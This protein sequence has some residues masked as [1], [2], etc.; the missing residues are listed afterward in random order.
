MACQL[1]DGGEE[2]LVPTRQNH[3]QIRFQ[4]LAFRGRWCLD[5]TQ[6]H[7]DLDLHIAHRSTLWQVGP[8]LWEDC[9]QMVGPVRDGWVLACPPNKKSKQTGCK[10]HLQ[11]APGG[12]SPFGSAKPLHPGMAIYIDLDLTDPRTWECR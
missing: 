3:D 6:K 2:M 8:H 11:Y 1:M 5:C 7:V 4:G 10:R 12:G 9:A